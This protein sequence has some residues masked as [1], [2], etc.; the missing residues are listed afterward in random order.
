MRI[1][2]TKIPA[3]LGKDVSFNYYG[4]RVFSQFKTV[5]K[6]IYVI[7]HVVLRAATFE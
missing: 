1:F 7:I 4:T 2:L 5:G 3:F 6:F